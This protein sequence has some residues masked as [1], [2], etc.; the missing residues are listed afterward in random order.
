MLEEQRRKERDKKRLQR[1]KRS[2]CR[3]AKDN[4]QQADYRKS[5]E[6]REA[7]IKTCRA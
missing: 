5:E 7:Y 4:E 1:A 3:R 6:G 2:P